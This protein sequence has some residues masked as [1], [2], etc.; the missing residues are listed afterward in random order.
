M[1]KAEAR[2]G[3]YYIQKDG[4]RNG[5]ISPPLMLRHVYALDL[6]W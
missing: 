1:A 2:E 4:R 6:V 3:V 5:R